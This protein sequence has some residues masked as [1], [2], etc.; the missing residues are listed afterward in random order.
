MKVIL[1]ILTILISKKMLTKKNKKET[2]QTKK[3]FK[4]ITLINSQMKILLK[5]KYML[6]MIIKKVI[7]MIIIQLR[8]KRDVSIGKIKETFS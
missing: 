8:E 1:K 5:R 6:I 3:L 4:E 2:K 7:K